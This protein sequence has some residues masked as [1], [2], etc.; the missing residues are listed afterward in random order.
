MAYFSNFP[1]VFYQF[2]NEQTVNSFPDISA[3]VDIIDQIKDDVNFYRYYTILDGDRPDI[4]SQKLYGS[5]LFYWTFFLLNDNLKQQGW[6]LS[7]QRLEEK[8]KEDFPNTTVTTTTNL[9]GVFLP[10]QTI[11]G[12][13]SGAEATIIKRRLDFGQ[14]IVSGTHEFTNGEIITSTV[15]D[16]LQTA[17]V[18]SSVEE[19]NS[20]HHYEDSEGKYVDIDPA[21]G[22]AALYTPITFFDR[23]VASNDAL[24]DIKVIRA[25]SINDLVAAFNDA[26]RS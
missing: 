20:V 17:T 3:Y 10:G 9:T 19:Y 13:S 4:V 22:N 21:V 18:T 26:L 11:T 5:P 24:K 6:P 25:R 16:T 2:G 23:Y 1:S 15:G 12:L 14:L 8:V 7:V